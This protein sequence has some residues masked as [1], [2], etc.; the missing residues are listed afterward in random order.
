MSIRSGGRE[1][2]NSVVETRR[3]AGYNNLVIAV[4]ADDAAGQQEESDD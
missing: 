1:Q 3:D 2:I 4:T